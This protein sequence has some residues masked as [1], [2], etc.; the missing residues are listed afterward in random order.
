MKQVFIY[1]DNKKNGIEI[2]RVKSNTILE[3]DTAC[4]QATGIDP[5]KSPWIGCSL[6]P[7]HKLLQIWLKFLTH[8][9]RIFN[10]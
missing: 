5:I 7:K 3:A 4:K 10:F 9:H 6:K 2:F 8:L 1:C